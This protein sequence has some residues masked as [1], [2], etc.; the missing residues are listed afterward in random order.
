MMV[1]INDRLIGI[2]NRFR[3]RRVN[4]QGGSKGTARSISLDESRCQ[5]GQPGA[6]RILPM[7]SGAQIRMLSIRDSPLWPMACTR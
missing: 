7:D 3:G 2:E 5:L 4:H 1:R 6:L